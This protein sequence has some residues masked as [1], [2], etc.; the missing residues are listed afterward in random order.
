MIK[1]RLLWRLNENVCKG[2]APGKVDSDISFLGS[3]DW[4]FY[5]TLELFCTH[6]RRQLGLYCPAMYNSKTW[7]WILLK[8]LAIQKVFIHLEVKK[9]SYFLKQQEPEVWPWR[10]RTLLLTK[11]NSKR[12]LIVSDT[13]MKVISVEAKWALS[14]KELWGKLILGVYQRVI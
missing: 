6:S 1:D 14:L 5:C 8:N 4:E 9:N 7:C 10:R 12:L 13:I 3:W 2:L 11:K